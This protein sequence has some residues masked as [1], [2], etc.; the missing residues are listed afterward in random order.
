[1]RTVRLLLAVA[2]AAALL[3]S[4]AAAGEARGRLVYEETVAAKGSVA[5]SV[6][7]RRPASFSV[8]LRT[9][10][11]G[12]TKLFLLGKDAPR[13]GPLMDTATY[14][15][16]GAAGSFYCRGAYEPLPAGTYTFRIVYRGPAPAP[17]ALTLRW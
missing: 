2:G 9:V 4:P 14:A 11:T 8:V 7:V 5:V 15:C 10:T 16:D 6:T 3:A 13:G 12:R 17:V 1:M